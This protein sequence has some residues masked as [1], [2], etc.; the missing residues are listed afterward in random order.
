MSPVQEGSVVVYVI[1]KTF[2]MRGKK[3][4]VLKAFN[5]LTGGVSPPNVRLAALAYGYDGSSSPPAME[6]LKGNLFKFVAPDDI[7][8]NT[9]REKLTVYA[10]YEHFYPGIM[11]A[12]K[13]I[14]DE[15]SPVAK[16]WCENKVI[17]ALGNGVPGVSP[18]NADYFPPPDAGAILPTN[19]LSGLKN[20]GIQVD[21]LCVGAGG[22]CSKNMARC[23]SQPQPGTVLIVPWRWCP[24][25]YAIPPSNRR[26][27][28]RDIMDTIATHTG[29]VP[30]GVAR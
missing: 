24:G 19:L 6:T 18:M 14:E 3:E 25:L 4:A 17:V 7:P 30:H 20:A 26:L 29:G 27:R 5:D 12:W 22:Y 11:A 28:G 1:D 15:C 16:P 8:A 13:M 23:P 21:T 10:D 9:L 2:S